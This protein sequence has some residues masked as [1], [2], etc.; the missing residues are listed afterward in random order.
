MKSLTIQQIMLA[1]QLVRELVIANN[2]IAKEVYDMQMLPMVERMTVV[3]VIGFLASYNIVWS[4][5]KDGFRKE[6]E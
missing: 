1:T 5:E 6:T 3:E 2:N 4:E